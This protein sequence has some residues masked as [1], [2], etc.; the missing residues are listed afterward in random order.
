MCHQQSSVRVCVTLGCGLVGCPFS[1]PI[2]EGTVLSHMTQPTNNTENPVVS[3]EKQEP[4][5]E[6]DKE[7]VAQHAVSKT[8][9]SRAAVPAVVA[10]ATAATTTTAATIQ[11]LPAV[12]IIECPHWVDVLMPA[13]GYQVCYS[14]VLHVLCYILH[15]TFNGIYYEIQTVCVDCFR[16]HFFF[17]L[18]HQ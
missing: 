4:P 18:T 10:A 14:F 1:S 8:T 3:A 6:T 9:H 5:P 13:S 12:G 16:E 17:L 2:I 15:I 11:P 7:A